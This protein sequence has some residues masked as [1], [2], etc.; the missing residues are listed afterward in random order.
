MADVLSSLLS[1]I[2]TAKSIMAELNDLSPELGRVLGAFMKNGNSNAQIKSAISFA[3]KKITSDPYYIIGVTRSDSNE[4]IKQVYKLKAKLYHPDNQ[5][6]GDNEKFIQ[7]EKA[8]RVVKA[9]RGL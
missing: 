9:E 2:R 1:S 5:D 4:V 3:V 7:L 6:T 8:W